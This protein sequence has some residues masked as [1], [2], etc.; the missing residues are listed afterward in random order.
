MHSHRVFLDASFWIA[1]RDEREACHAGAR[2]VLLEL[3]RHRSQFL[4][5]TLVFAEIHA[6]FS[7]S[8][9]K[10]EQV[11][12][13]FWENPLVH[14]EPVSYADQQAAVMLL[15]QQRDKSYSFC[16]AVSFVIL[17]RL[18]VRRVASLDDHFRQLGEFE[19]LSGAWPPGAERE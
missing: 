10:R 18:E 3:F 2:Q 13:D 8:L 14:F 7:R 9:P 1:V 19:V 4:T 11:L 12:T 17:R 5:T 15:R 16:D 6:Y